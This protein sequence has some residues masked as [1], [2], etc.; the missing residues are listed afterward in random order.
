MCIFDSSKQKEIM[1]NLITPSIEKRALELIAN[2]MDVLEAVKTA[3]ID[4]T[5]ILGS[6]IDGQNFTEKGK[7]ARDYVFN[8]Y[9]K[10]I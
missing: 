3:L 5:N 2:G 9:M 1:K 6:L 10:S 4:E 8:N 7:V